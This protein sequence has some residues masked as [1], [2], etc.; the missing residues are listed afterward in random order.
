MN[1]AV[2]L[3]AR[4][5]DLVGTDRIAVELP[6]A[7]TV[8]DLRTALAAQHAPLRPLSRNLLMAVGTDYV[9]DQTVLP[10]DCE[11]ACFP[12]VSGG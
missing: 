10:A 2:R 1:V 9:S 3:F 8:A 11:V 6:A 7:A 5:R 4:A 12:P